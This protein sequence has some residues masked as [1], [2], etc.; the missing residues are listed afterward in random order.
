VKGLI[1]QTAFAGKFEWQYIYGVS[2]T[3]CKLGFS[4]GSHEQ[5]AT[6]VVD[7][8]VELL[9]VFDKH[10]SQGKLFKFPSKSKVSFKEIMCHVVSQL[11]DLAK[12]GIS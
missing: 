1:T 6:F 8:M 7:S 3:L 2:L 10:S 9:L 11:I 12:T 4:F 5:I